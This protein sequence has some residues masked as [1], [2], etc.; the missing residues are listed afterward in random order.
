MRKPLYERSWLAA[1]VV[2]V[3]AL[4]LLLLGA[5]VASRAGGAAT[6]A[7]GSQS[8][9]A[10]MSA[11]G[12]EIIFLATALF[13][14]FRLGEPPRPGKFMPALAWGVCGGAAILALDWLFTW[15]SSLAGL[16]VG[17]NPDFIPHA[18]NEWIGWAVTLP[19]VAVGEELFF[20]GLLPALYRAVNAPAG[21]SLTLAC[22][23]FGLIHY[24]Q[25]VAAPFIAAL[26]ALIFFFLKNKSGGL[27]APVIAH[28]LVDTAGLVL[29]AHG[30]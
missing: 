17:L 26:L 16:R 7:T 13:F 4:C 2:T 1:A 28:L 12:Y 20:R 24:G 21:M 19:F 15:L 11:L 25:G 5:V 10:A 27:L 30:A 23:L 22:A 14:L 9:G 8:F 3:F 18:R 29:A 6:E